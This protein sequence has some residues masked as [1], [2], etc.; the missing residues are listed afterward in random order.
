MI[1]PRA[2]VLVILRIYRA[3]V[4]PYLGPACRFEPSCSRYATEAVDVHGVWRG[5]WLT[6][7]RLLRCAP[8]GGYGLDPVPREK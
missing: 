7:L 8:W 6:L 1:G 4:S 5:G 2:L 3:C